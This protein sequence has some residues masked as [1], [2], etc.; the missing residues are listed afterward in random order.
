MAKLAVRFWNEFGV[1]ARCQDGSF[2][3]YAPHAIKRVVASPGGWKEKD[4]DPYQA[5]AFQ[6]ESAAEAKVVGVNVG[7]SQQI[8]D[9]V[10]APAKTKG[11][12]G[13]DAIQ[14]QIAV[15]C[16]HCG[17]EMIPGTVERGPTAG[18]PKCSLCG[19]TIKNG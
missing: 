2:V 18:Q 8:S 13:H 19:K 6:K 11:V 3:W 9:P 14:Q 4:F 7:I 1:W 16:P 12:G 17:G 15:K 5:S 10:Q